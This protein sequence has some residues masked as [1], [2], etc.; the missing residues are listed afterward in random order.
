MNQTT[1]ISVDPWDPW[2]FTAPFLADSTFC[3]DLFNRH[4]RLD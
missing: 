2:D 4:M 3:G 1:V